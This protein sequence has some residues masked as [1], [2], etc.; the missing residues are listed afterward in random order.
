MKAGT[1]SPD[2]KELGGLLSILLHLGINMTP[3]GI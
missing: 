3:K 1:D 2:F